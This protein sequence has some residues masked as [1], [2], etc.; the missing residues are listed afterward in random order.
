[1]PYSVDLGL[2]YRFHLYRVSYARVTFAASSQPTQVVHHCSRTAWAPL[3][4]NGL[5]A[6]WLICLADNCRRPSKMLSPYLGLHAARL[7]CFDMHARSWLP[8]RCNRP[9]KLAEVRPLV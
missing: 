3:F 2:G 7:L 1:M 5:G 6:P 9:L 8:S 4:R